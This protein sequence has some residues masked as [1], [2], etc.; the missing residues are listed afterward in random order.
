MNLIK[1][2][3]DKLIESNEYTLDDISKMSEDDIRH[4]YKRVYYTDDD[5]ILD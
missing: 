1:I 4:A 5:W 2:L 3:I